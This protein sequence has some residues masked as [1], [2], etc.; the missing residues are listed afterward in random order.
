MVRNG[1]G[2]LK[3]FGVLYRNARDV[4]LSPLYDVVTTSIYRYSR[5]EEGPELEDRTLALRLFRK[6]R[7]KTYPLGD[8]LLHF[9][10]SVCGVAD[11]GKVTTRIAQAM[12][13]VLAQAPTDGRIPG[14]T[15]EKMQVAWETGMACQAQIKV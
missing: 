10:R 14:Q 15:L 12:H 13:E 4:R 2:H 6:S 8:E 1:D 7:S 9:G 11:P 3:N 5:Y